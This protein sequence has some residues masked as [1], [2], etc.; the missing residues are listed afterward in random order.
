PEEPVMPGVLLIE[1]LAQSGGILA[2]STLD[3]PQNYRT[4][5]V[6]IENVKFRHKVVPGDT[7][8]FFCQLSGPMRRGLI[9]MKGAAYVGDKVVMEAEMIAQLQRK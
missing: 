5:F 8:V 6:K 9:I 2:A 3:D 4:L 1:A 7:L